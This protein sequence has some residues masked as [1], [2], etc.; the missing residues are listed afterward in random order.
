MCFSSVGKVTSKVFIWWFWWV[1]SSRQ[2][3]FIFSWCKKYTTYLLEVQLLRLCQKRKLDIKWFLLLCEK[4]NKWLSFIFIMNIEPFNSL[5]TFWQFIVINKS[6]ALVTYETVLQL[7]V[8]LS[9]LISD[10][11][12]VVSKQNGCWIK[13]VNTVTTA[14]HSGRNITFFWIMINNFISNT[15]HPHYIVLDW[16]KFHVPTLFFYFIFHP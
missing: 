8:E 6:E 16:N 4:E 2:Q 14:P 3:W 15:D 1:D 12:T 9:F 10:Q 13:P 7:N 11:E 5:H